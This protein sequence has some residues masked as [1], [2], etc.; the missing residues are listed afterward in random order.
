[1]KQAY[2]KNYYG[3]FGGYSW[4]LIE[5]TGKCK[6]VSG[7]FYTTEHHYYQVQRR[8]LGIPIFKEWVHEGN[9]EYYTPVIETEYKCNC[10][11]KCQ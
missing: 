5:L 9:I 8:F 7:G 11:E 1:M 10:G 3:D 4:G 2:E 6:K